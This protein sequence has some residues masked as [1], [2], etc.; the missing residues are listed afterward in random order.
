MRRIVIGAATA[1]MLAGA[2]LGPVGIPAIAHAQG[3]GRVAPAIYVNDSVITGYE[4]EQ[5]RL[6]LRVLNAPETD[7]A[8]AEQALIDDRLRSFAAR[9]AG[10]TVSDEQ[11]SAAQAEFASRGGLGTEQFVQLLARQGVDRRTFEDFVLSGL[12]WREFVRA[13]IVGQ[14]RVTDAEVDEAMKKLIE[15]PVITH[16]ALSELVIP[17]PEGQEAQ[18]MALAERIVRETRGE[19]QFAAFARQYSATQSRENGGRL[20]MLPLANLPPSL[21][22]ILLQLKPGQVSPPLPVKGAVVLFFLRDARGTQRPGASDQILDYA[23]L[24]LASADEGARIAALANTCDDLFVLARGLPPETL[25]R[26]TLPLAQVPAG[27]AVRL[28]S[29]DDNEAT[30]ATL[31]G[32]AELLMLCKRSPALLENPPAPEAAPEP[33]QPATTA[34]AGGQADGQPPAGPA[35]DALPSRDEVRSQL[36]NRKVAAAA[37]NF[38]AELRGNA[39]I[40]RP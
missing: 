38:L 31:G 6:F 20:P 2:G 34:A 28:A 12:L 30:V 39:I 29:L 17:A 5:R 21:L 7:I 19:A 16:V 26:Q 18:A 3:A 9:Q 35:P 25:Q 24:R 10:I 27:D 33:A 14:A 32:G 22:P 4:I 8:R 36:Y 15:T 11:I 1:A 23:R 13:R 40:R 37:D